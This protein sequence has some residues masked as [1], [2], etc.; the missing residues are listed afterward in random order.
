MLLKLKYDDVKA[1]GARGEVNGKMMN[2]FMRVQV[3]E[4]NLVEA[5][6]KFK[7]NKWVV[8]LDYTGEVGFLKTVEVLDK[9]II[10]TKEVEKVDLN[11]DFIMSDIDNRVRVVFSLPEN[12][13][14]MRTI[15][16]YSQKY[17]NIRFDGGKFI[18][19]DGCNVGA[20]GV[21]DIP[22]KIADSRIAV[23]TRGSAS[24]FEEVHI[25]DVDMVEF[26]DS[27]TVSTGRTKKKS[28]NNKTKKPKKQL[29]SLLSLVN[30]DGLNNF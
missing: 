27:K 10:V 30:A 11:V 5:M 18:K 21:D 17:T 20:I 19:L 14:D 1:S 9:T 29:S 16:D 13:S 4:L 7:S 28:S 22:K 8:A 3:D 2:F 6:Q 24:V 23:V 26:Y 15:Y 12:Y 25:D